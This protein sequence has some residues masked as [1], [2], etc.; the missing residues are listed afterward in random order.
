MNT[1]LPLLERLRDATREVHA[2]V[3]ALPFFV[4]LQAG[5]L[6]RADYVT[7]LEAMATIQEALEQAAATAHEPLLAACWHEDLRRLPL[8]QHDLLHFQAER[9]DTV[10]RPLLHAIMLAE[11]IAL[12]ERRDPPS[13]LGSLY[14]LQGSALGGLV[15][16]P[17]VA[18]A[19]DLRGTDGLA[20]LAGT[21]Q[22]TRRVWS[23]F[24]AA[25]NTAVLA[26][27]LQQRVVDAALEAFDGMEQLIGSL[28]PRA[29]DAFAT[30]ASTLNREAGSHAITADPREIRAA[31]RAGARSWERF[32]YYEWRYGR[33]GRRFTRSD[34]AWLVTLAGLPQV[35]VDRHIAWLGQVLAARG[36]PRWLLEL[37]L[38]ALHDEL[39]SA[40]PER[41]DDYRRLL[42]A[43]QRLREQRTAVL[44][45]DVWRS[46]EA[47]FDAAVGTG[48]A[49]RLPGSGGLLAAAVSDEVAGVKNAEASLAGWMLDPAR[50][51]T[52]WITAVRQTL[53][54]AR[55]QA[56]PGG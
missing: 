36:M 24:T 44:S 22:Q 21:G 31:L 43:A 13:L 50:F 16:R 18:W 14:V 28:Y 3:E 30:L 54:E 41:Q 53:A 49:Q 8:L 15:L 39:V 38:E 2:R 51:P 55:R 17:Q 29:T 27:A 52:S 4:A 32:P 42:R 33:R 19:F 26:P 7:F 23:A 20:Y 10:S 56:R 1:D 6:P 35:V 25:L 11:E 45:N 46:L 40:V 34:S 5:A 12:R 37:H 47:T 9:S 48:W